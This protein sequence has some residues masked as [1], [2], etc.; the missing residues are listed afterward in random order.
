[1]NITPTRFTEDLARIPEPKGENY[2][3][4]RSLCDAGGFHISYFAHFVKLQYNSVAFAAS[5]EYLYIFVSSA[6]GVM[7]KVGTGEGT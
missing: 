5:K 7:L 2:H 1:M 3:Y 4:M 6:N